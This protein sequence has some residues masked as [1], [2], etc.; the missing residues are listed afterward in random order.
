[1]KH[2]MHKLH[3]Y[4]NSTYDADTFEAHFY[5]TARKKIHIKLYLMCMVKILSLKINT[6]GNHKTNLKAHALTYHIKYSKF[7]NLYL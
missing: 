3:A 1:M 5:V 7:R 2:T 6:K 4:M